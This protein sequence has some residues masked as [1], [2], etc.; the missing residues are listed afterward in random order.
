VT[1]INFK[2]LDLLLSMLEEDVAF[3]SAHEA[4]RR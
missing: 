2:N 1:S 4:A 3:L